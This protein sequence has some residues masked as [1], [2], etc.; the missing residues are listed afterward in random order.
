M[1]EELVSKQTDLDVVGRGERSWRS[2]A[3]CAE[4]TVK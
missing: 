4:E 2:Q 1:Q 3:I